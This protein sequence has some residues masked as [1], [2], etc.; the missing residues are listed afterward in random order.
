MDK[1]DQIEQ[2]KKLLSISTPTETSMFNQL[3]KG[4][5]GSTLSSIDIATK[6]IVIDKDSKNNK[7][8]S[9]LKKFT[10]NKSKSFRFFD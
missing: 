5:Y 10:K 9:A 2:R 7:N 1:K 6:T 4:A 3:K 8:S